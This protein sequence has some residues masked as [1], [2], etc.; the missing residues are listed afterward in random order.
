MRPLYSVG[1]DVMLVS[2]FRPDLNGPTTVLEVAPTSTEGTNGCTR[3]R[4]SYSL[5]TPSPNEMGW[6]ECALR[7]RPPKTVSFDEIMDGLKQPVKVP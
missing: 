5:A 7:K 1:E 2:D 3:C 6:H 4:F